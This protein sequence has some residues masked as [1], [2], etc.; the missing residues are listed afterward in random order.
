MGKEKKTEK[1][2]KKKSRRDEDDEEN[3][4]RLGRRRTTSQAHSGQRLG[5][6]TEDEMNRALI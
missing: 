1:K 3:V 6:W 2:P 4:D 5:T